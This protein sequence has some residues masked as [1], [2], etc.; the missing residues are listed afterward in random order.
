MTATR[1]ILSDKNGQFIYR[2]GD[3]RGTVGGKLPSGVRGTS[4]WT[5]VGRNA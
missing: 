3:V 5:P 4:Y 2:T 1:E